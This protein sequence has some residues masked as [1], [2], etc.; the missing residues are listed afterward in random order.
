MVVNDDYWGRYP[1][2][3][4]RPPVRPEP[5]PPRPAPNIVSCDVFKCVDSKGYSHPRGQIGETV[6]RP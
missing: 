1:Y 6:R 4:P 2:G 5:Q 3:H